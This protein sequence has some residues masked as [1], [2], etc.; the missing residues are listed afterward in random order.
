MCA[1]LCTMLMTHFRGH[2]E[3][4]YSDLVFARFSS[5]G[6]PAL[7][8][9]ACHHIRPGGGCPRCHAHFCYECLTLYS[10]QQNGAFALTDNFVLHQR[11]LRLFSGTVQKTCQCAVYCDASCHCPP[12]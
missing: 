10:V 9:S 7:L 3:A 11:C 1:Q 2:G 8:Q 6:L 4:K 5:F 12:W